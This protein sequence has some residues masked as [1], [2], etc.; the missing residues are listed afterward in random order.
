LAAIA[1]SAFNAGKLCSV[2]TRFTHVMAYYLMV[3]FVSNRNNGKNGNN[4]KQE[5]ISNHQ[6]EESAA[7]TTVEESTT[8]NQVF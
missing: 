1:K 4:E 6:E 5:Y 8:T 3:G 2:P 7:T